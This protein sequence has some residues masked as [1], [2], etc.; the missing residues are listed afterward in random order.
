MHDEWDNRGC[1]SKVR[2]IES[3][4]EAVIFRSIAK[5]DVGEKGLGTRLTFYY[6]TLF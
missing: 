3:V 4:E 6:N 1:I 2:I 5:E